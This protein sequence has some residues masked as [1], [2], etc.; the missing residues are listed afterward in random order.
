MLA[1]WVRTHFSIIS[2]GGLRTCSGS[3]KLVPL[4]VDSTKSVQWVALTQTSEGSK[5][6]Q[7]PA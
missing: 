2:S 3:K 5:V 1:L 7:S 6:G 4:E